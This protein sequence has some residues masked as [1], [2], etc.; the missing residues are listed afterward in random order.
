[1]RPAKDVICEGENFVLK[2][3][4]EGVYYL[5]VP[6]MGVLGPGNVMFHVENMVKTAIQNFPAPIKSIRWMES[7]E[8]LQFTQN[9][10]DV[11]VDCTQYEYGRNYV[12]RVAKIEV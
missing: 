3:D 4:E 9:G 10:G 1:M 5:F 8:E 12:V 7:G 11:T 2:A 6:D